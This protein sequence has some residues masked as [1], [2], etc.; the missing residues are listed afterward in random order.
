[1]IYL[2]CNACAHYN[3]LRSEFLTFC[4]HCG[5]KLPDNYSEW[6]QKHPESDFEAFRE[7]IAVQKET[8]G[9]G[10]FATWKQQYLGI[11]GKRGFMLTLVLIITLAAVAGGYYGKRVVLNMF[12]PRVAENV[13]YVSWETVTIGKKAL[14]IS[15]PMHIGVN[16]KPLD[17][18]IAQ[19]VDYAKSYRN[20]VV[21]GMEV[22]VDMYSYRGHV[23]NSLKSAGAAVTREM[24]RSEE[25][26]D[27]KY[28]TNPVI[29]GG[30]NALLQEGDYTYK[31]AIRLSFHNLLLVQGQHRWLVRIRHRADDTTANT[32]AQ[33]IIKS[34][35]IK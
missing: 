21:E 22:E 3:E 15:T 19:L 35:R 28:A 23:S 12:Y 18:E 5:R 7:E 31:S 29:L 8:P 11:V 10:R 14:V 33:R 20:R 27:L 32:A 26:A 16:D 13:M 1:M 9:I 24:E 34:I 2:K 30:M 6:K 25:I 4:G 17:K